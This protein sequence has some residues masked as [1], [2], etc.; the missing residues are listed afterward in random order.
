MKRL[1]PF[2][3]VLLVACSNTKT[4]VMSLDNVEFS[5]SGIERVLEVPTSVKAG[6]AIKIRVSVASG[7][8]GGFDHFDTNRTPDRLELTP[9]GIE[10]IGAI[11]LAVY[12]T[13]WVGFFDSPT[14]PRSNPFKVIVHRSNGADLERSITI[15][16]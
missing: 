2:M 4:F 5:E 1:L 14:S 10:Q 6:E 11:C 15:T 9:I 12:N 13:K 8:C 7:G 3:V 16:P